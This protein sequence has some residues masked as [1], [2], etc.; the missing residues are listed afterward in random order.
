MRLLSVL[1]AFIAIAAQQSVQDAAKLQVMESGGSL[2]YKVIN[3]SPYRIVGF[4]IYTQFTSGGFEHL[5]C[6]VNADVRAEKDL[7]VTG[8]CK[9]PDDEKTGKSVTYR[10]RIVRVKF[11]NELTWSPLKEFE[12]GTPSKK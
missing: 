8:V 10:S 4:M 6:T 3:Q 11:E 9:L 5:G 12:N 1:L 7:S 2:S